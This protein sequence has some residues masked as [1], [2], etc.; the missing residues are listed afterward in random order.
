MHNFKEFFTKNFDYTNL[1]EA[2]AYRGT[3]IKSPTL[4]D[5]EDLDFLYQIDQSYWVKALQQRIQKTWNLLKNRKDIQN[6]ISKKILNAIKETFWGSQGSQKAYQRRSQGEKRKIDLNQENLKNL[7]LSLSEKYDDYGQESSGGSDKN[8]SELSD[9]LDKLL[10]N[11]DLT[12]SSTRG[13]QDNFRTIRDLTHE[14]IKHIVTHVKGGDQEEYYVGDKKIK[15]Y[16]NRY[17]EKFETL[18]GD[19]H[20]IK[21]KL[22]SLSQV[23]GKDIDFESRGKYGIDLSNA[24]KI[25][26]KG[27][28]DT[29]YKVGSGSDGHGADERA[30]FN[31]PKISGVM[32]A[33]KNLYSLNYHRHYGSLPSDDPSHD[34]DI[35]YRMV[36][37]GR[38]QPKPIGDTEARNTIQRNIS[39]FITRFI[40]NNKKLG[41]WSDPKI[42]DLLENSPFPSKEKEEM[43]S[44]LWL[45]RHILKNPSA[46][47]QDLSTIDESA[48]KNIFHD[49]YD[50]VEKW[51]TNGKISMSTLAWMTQPGMPLE[52]GEAG[53]NVVSN[54]KLKKYFAEYFSNERTKEVIKQQNI[55]GPKI[56]SLVI[57]GDPV[58][59][60]EIRK[61]ELAKIN[62]EDKEKLEKILGAEDWESFLKTG[63][64]P[65]KIKG[66]GKDLK[67]GATRTDKKGEVIEGESPKIILPYVKI[68]EGENERSVPLLNTPSFITSGVNVDAVEVSKLKKIIIADLKKVKIN[69][70]LNSEDDLK[71][72]LSLDKIED[73]TK[74]LI[75]KLIMLVGEDSE[76]SLMTTSRSG[77]IIGKDGKETILNNF[78]K[79]SKYPH[80]IPGTRIAG[81]RPEVSSQAPGSP[82]NKETRIGFA[83]IFPIG[84][85]VMGSEGL[86]VGKE[87][88][89]YFKRNPQLIPKD[90]SPMN[91]LQYDLLDSGDG[92]GG[93]SNMESFRLSGFKIIKE[94]DESDDDIER[95]TSG[96]RIGGKLTAKWDKAKGSHH[97]YQISPAKDGNGN[98]SGWSDIVE[99]ISHVFL[100]KKYGGVDAN[101]VDIIEGIKDF[102]K[103]HDE[104]VDVFYINAKD[105]DLYNSLGRKTRASSEADKFLSREN[106]ATG[107]KGR[108]SRTST[109][110]MVMR[111]PKILGDVKV[112]INTLQPLVYSKSLEKQ[113]RSQFVSVFFDTNN[114]IMFTSNSGKTWV[115]SATMPDSTGGAEPYVFRKNKKDLIS[116]LYGTSN[117]LR[118]LSENSEQVAP[119]YK[120]KIIEML[121]LEKKNLLSYWFDIFPK[122]ARSYETAMV[123][124]GGSGDDLAVYLHGCASIP[125]YIE[126]IYEDEKVELEKIK[127]AIQQPQQEVSVDLKTRQEYNKLLSIIEEIKAIVKDEDYNGSYLNFHEENKKEN[128]NFSDTYNWYKSILGLSA[129]LLYSKDISRNET[130]IQ[131]ILNHMG[132]LSN[133]GQ[134]LKFQ[135]HMFLNKISDNFNE[136]ARLLR[137]LSQPEVSGAEAL[138]MQKK[139]ALASQMPKVWSTINSAFMAQAKTKNQPEVK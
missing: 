2:R 78:Y 8:R 35:T 102:Q 123:G 19:E 77:V 97:Y 127:I 13:Y 31:F 32:E 52:D 34:R 119:T 132:G 90:V 83:K 58:K 5:E 71:E 106:E 20:T 15:F 122:L 64:I 87:T 46:T 28:K 23:Y 94:A 116:R 81:F 93:V 115:P 17:I 7:I 30:G 135:T 66:E 112:D 25:K 124:I 55:H 12:N 91:Y 121:E 33:L 96:A 80:G 56:L 74:N 27:G 70:N 47:A 95:D 1:L 120:K 104:I 129:A 9:W 128:K 51:K 139:D 100:K 14:V 60:E 57:T 61:R 3:Y 84:R 49:N 85:P 18:P 67:I 130:L 36:R 107:S 40:N 138:L 16:I 89:D 76:K 105:E 108:K 75:K 110:S 68:G 73:K 24:R 131:V 72:L 53:W 111:N 126:D 69:S 42:A 10:V 79:I 82:H 63:R 59:D 117:L 38:E 109:E 44:G 86:L 29:I 103:I 62:I 41:S 88:W 26:S 22:D 4:L 113:K 65:Y 39:N 43:E 99:G 45:I 133:V 136:F 54:T 92:P 37:S 21:T 134:G 101:M 137:Q 50:Q 11:Y 125:I 118:F 48:F 114:Q 6:I 98:I